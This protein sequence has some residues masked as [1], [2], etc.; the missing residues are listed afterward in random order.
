MEAEAEQQEILESAP[1]LVYALDSKGLIVSLNREAI[2]V[3]GY[4]RSEL[5]GSSAF[6]LMHPGDLDRVKAGFAE[7]VASKD[8]GIRQVEFRII[9]KSG[10]V[11]HLEVKRRLIFEDGEV[12]RNEGIARDVSERVRLEE[13]LLLYREIINNSTDAVVILDTEGH[14]L[15]QNPAHEKLMGYSDEDLVGQTPAL[16]GGDELFREISTALM[17]HGLYRNE[18]VSHTKAGDPVE[19]DLLAFCVKDE[20]GEL[21]CTVGFARDI[22]ERKRGEARWLARQRVREEIWKMRGAD[23]IDDVL[24]AIRESLEKLK[25]DYRDCRINVMVKGDCPPDCAAYRPDVESDELVGVR[26]VVELPFSHGTL[27]VDSTQ[28]DA[29]SEEEINV[30]QELANILSEGFQR[31]A[32]LEDLNQANLQ[33]VNAEKMAALGNLIAGIAHEINTPIGGD[34]QYA[35]HAG[36]GGGET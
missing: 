18:V 36:A 27:S 5:L 20:A 35:G 13:R 29:F 3:L 28:P 14:Y 19:V 6:E 25:I 7:A 10:V 8:D 16:H 31:M 21:I 2:D 26:S 32:D 22:S 12:V 34:S 1:D 23:G 33:L 30:L 15:E 17:R 9:T 11:R 4:D 24:A